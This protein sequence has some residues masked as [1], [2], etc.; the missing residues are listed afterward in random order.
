M[1]RQNEYILHGDAEAAVVDIIKNNTPELAGYAPFTVSTD[2]V[3]YVKGALWIE[4]A[5]N[6]GSYKF[7]RDKRS[8]IDITVYAPSG[9]DGRG[10]AY[11]IS[12]IIQASLFA[13]QNS[14]TGHGVFF[15]ACQM[16]TD[17]FR[18]NDKE[19]DPVR[20]VQSLRLLL[21]PA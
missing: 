10:I 15:Q 5:L 3:G 1:P 2:M 19:E 6:G 17:L 8:R 12:A 7:L 13:W 21:L 18:A 20:Y 4:V 14:Y 9:A 16:E 11:D